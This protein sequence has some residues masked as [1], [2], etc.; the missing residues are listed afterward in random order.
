MPDSVNS[1]NQTIDYQD[2]ANC[3]GFSLRK[4]SRAISQMYDE[5]FRSIGIRGTQFSLLT[6]IKTAEPVLVT[7]LAEFTV[8][9]RTTLTRNLDILVKQELVQISAGKDRR[10]RMVSLSPQGEMILANA[11]PLWQQTQSQIA[12]LMSAHRLQHLLSELGE[13]VKAVQSK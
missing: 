7:R 1:N 12:A 3:T 13:L 2:C 10:T 5:A 6:A 11:Y 9:D 8:M 4:A